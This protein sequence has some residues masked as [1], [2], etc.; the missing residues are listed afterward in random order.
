VR[1]GISDGTYTVVSSPDLQE[2]MRVAVGTSAPRTS[3]A[4]AAQ[5]PMRGRGPAF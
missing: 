5:A 2:G 3:N 1:T 4:P